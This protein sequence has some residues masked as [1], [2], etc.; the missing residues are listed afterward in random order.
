MPVEFQ[1]TPAQ[2]TPPEFKSG[3][4]EINSTRKESQQVFLI[5]IQS[6]PKDGHT[7]STSENP[8]ICQSLGRKKFDKKIAIFR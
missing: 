7:F 4:F 3:L 1:P 5:N 2:T 6:S 8:K